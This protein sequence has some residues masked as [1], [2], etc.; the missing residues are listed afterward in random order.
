MHQQIKVYTQY[1]LDLI[2]RG[3]FALFKNLWGRQTNILFLGLDNSG[4]TT[5]LLRLKS[6]TVHTVAPTLS[7]RQETLQIGNHLKM[8]ISDLGGHETARLGWSTF[9]VQSHGIIFMI[10]ITDEARYEL[11]RETYQSLL[12]T[13]ENSGRKS[14]PIAVLFNKTDMWQKYWESKHK[15]EMAPPLDDSYLHYLCQIIGIRTGDGEDGR[16]ISANFCSVVTDSTTNQNKGFMLAFKWLD[17]M[18]RTPK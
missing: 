11:V 12:V 1:V 13:I 10:D 8:T 9:F 5:L 7:V 18:I 2:E 14:I 6:D 17:M 3:P 4:K 16:R 15:G